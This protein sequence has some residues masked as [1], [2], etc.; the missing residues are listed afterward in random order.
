MSD[1]D[2]DPSVRAAKNFLLAMKD[3]LI[4]RGMAEE[5]VAQ[6]AKAYTHPRRI[7]IVRA[8]AFT[9]AIDPNELSAQLQISSDAFYRH[10]RLLKA[11]GVVQKTNGTASLLKPQTRLARDLLHIILA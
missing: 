9:G 2:P 4:T 7:D 11:L 10:F 3:A 5:E 1:P 8:L 6:A